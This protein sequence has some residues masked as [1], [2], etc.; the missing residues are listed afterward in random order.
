MFNKS[1]PQGIQWT[2]NSTSHLK[3]DEFSFK[4]LRTLGAKES[5]GAKD[6]LVGIQ[7]M[8]IA[9]GKTG[10]NERYRQILI[11]L[12]RDSLQ[13]RSN[14]IEYFSLKCLFLFELY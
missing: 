4:M 8:S 9:M 5:I 2:I 3:T 13:K 12:R 11:K 7:L 14:V 6:I 10:E 1:F